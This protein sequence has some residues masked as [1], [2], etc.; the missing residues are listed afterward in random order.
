MSTLTK[1]PCID[2]EPISINLCDY[3]DSPS[4]DMFE[5]TETKVSLRPLRY[6]TRTDLS[7]THAKYKPVRSAL[8]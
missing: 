2:C 8:G 4:Y 1:K 5:P 6:K 3:C 7:T